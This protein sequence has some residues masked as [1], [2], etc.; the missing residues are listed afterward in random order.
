M[1]R[2]LACGIEVFEEQWDVIKH[3]IENPVTVVSAGAGSGKTYTTVASVLELIETR[4]AQADQFILITFTRKAA[5]EL[6]NRLQEAMSK[7]ASS[8][9]DAD[10]RG[11][12]E[13][14]RERITAAYI[15]TIHGFC[16]SIL[17]L[18]GYS[19]GIAR[20]ASVSTAQQ[21]LSQAI[22]ETVEALATRDDDPLS[23]LT[24]PGGWE[25]YQLRKRLTEIFTKSRNQGISAQ[26]LLQATERQPDEES[27]RYRVRIA[28]IVLEVE[29]HYETACRNLQQL[30]A[31]ALLIKAAQLLTTCEDDRISKQIAE[32]FRFFFIDE[33]QDTSETQLV[34]ARAL[35]RYI[36]TLVVGDRKQ[37]IYA[38]TG[39]D[40]ALIDRFAEEN[41]TQP[42]SLR[43]SGRPTKPLLAIQNVLFE[44]MRRNFRA[45][46]D[47]L[48]PR[49]TSPE[50]KDKLP[51]FVIFSAPA[52]DRDRLLRLAIR[53]KGMI[54]TEIDREDVPDRKIAEGHI[55]VLTRTNEEVAECVAALRNVGVDARADSGTP[56]FHRPEVVAMYRFL[57]FLVRYPDDA[58]LVEALAT[59]HF[60][61]VDIN[62]REAHLLAYGHQRGTPL[63]DALS[64]R[65]T[66]LHKTIMDL[67]F[68][69]RTATVP[70]FLGA[71]ERAFGLKDHY[72]ELGLSDAAL[73]LD[74]LRDYARTLFDDD[75]AL[76]L[77]TFISILRRD[78]ENDRDLPEA[79][80]PAAGDPSFVRVMTI[81]RAKGLEF[82]IVVIPE[83]HQNRR[84]NSRPSSLV[85]P[86]HGLEVSVQGAPID[87]LSQGFRRQSAAALQHSL[88]EEMRLFYV[89]VTRAEHLVI[90][91][92]SDMT[93]PA[94]FPPR[95]TYSWQ[96]EVI[97]AR[98]T[99]ERLGAWFGSVDRRSPN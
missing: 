30:D 5:N 91:F 95:R 85:D 32:R 22:T 10:Q 23:P 66:D 24:F 94:P 81:H 7:R 89:A 18:Y 72:R 71:V 48:L 59:P 79:D 2:T 3:L 78:I 98:S 11:F 75:E 60:S 40:V 1:T 47:P 64:A 53:I 68:A 35:S 52:D 21:L 84:G 44:S 13:E 42:L 92:G 88:E 90:M 96:D 15:G 55:A 82:P 25:E 26:A 34:I 80:D 65:H 20:E 73:A 12:W 77:R 8:L 99:L 36:K 17:E 49:D 38:F 69:A 54:G 6:K 63:T 43:L 87:T 27:K 93:D 28:Q 58:A 37:A 46:G 56:F 19:I 33:F 86:D 51:P 39:A 9:S 31:A 50:P 14:Q 4:R 97:R 83:I 57:H 41:S 70:Q 74:R 62:D 76:T 45:L 16:R 61:E 67:R 29:E